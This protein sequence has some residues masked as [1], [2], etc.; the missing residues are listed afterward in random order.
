MTT[1]N[2]EDLFLYNG[3]T[4]LP[5]MNGFRFRTLDGSIGKLVTREAFYAKNNDLVKAEGLFIEWEPKQEKS[6]GKKGRR[7]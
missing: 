3:E 5:Y 6:N 7:K 4:C 2:N 1:K